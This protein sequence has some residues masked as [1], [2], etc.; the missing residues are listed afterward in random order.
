MHYA[1]VELLRKWMK[2]WEMKIQKKKVNEEKLKSFYRNGK[3]NHM[4]NQQ[5]L[6]EFSNS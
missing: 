5:P 1:L 4:G 6:T 3:S 2:T